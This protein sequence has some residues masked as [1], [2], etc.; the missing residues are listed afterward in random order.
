[1]DMV[2]IPVNAKTLHGNRVP[3]MK[4][5]ETPVQIISCRVE[6]GGD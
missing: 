5:T 2:N 3:I 4:K 6:N 1:M